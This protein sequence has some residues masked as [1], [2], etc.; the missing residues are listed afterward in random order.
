MISNIIKYYDEENDN[1]RLADPV[2][3]VERAAKYTGESYLVSKELENV[4]SQRSTIYKCEMQIINKF[5][6]FYLP[7]LKYITGNIA[8]VNI[9]CNELFQDK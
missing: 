9:S 1:K 2:K 8:F 4:T 6:T 7:L 3:A 5:N